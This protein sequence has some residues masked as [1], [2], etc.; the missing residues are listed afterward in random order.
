MTAQIF[1]DA[2]SF[3]FVFIQCL[4]RNTSFVWHK[5][6]SREGLTNRTKIELRWTYLKFDLN[7][8]GEKPVCFLKNRMKYEGSS[9]PR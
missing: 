4:I 1:K 3:I 7:A 5:S 6:I 8:S 9:Y 2:I